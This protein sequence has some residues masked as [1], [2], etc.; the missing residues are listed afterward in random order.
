M[1]RTHSV[2]KQPQIYLVKAHSTNSSG[3]RQNVFH[4]IVGSLSISVTRSVSKWLC[5]RMHLWRR[6]LGGRLPPHRP[7][8]HLGKQRGFKL[9]LETTRMRTHGACLQESIFHCVVNLSAG[10]PRAQHVD[11]VGGPHSAAAATAGCPAAGSAA[12]ALDLVERALGRLQP[13]LPAPTEIPARFR[14]RWCERQWQRGAGASYAYVKP[15]AVAS[16]ASGQCTYLAKSRSNFTIAQM[17]R[18]S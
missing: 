3:F 14:M 10:Q 15:A 16:A 2:L 13:L 12:G 5:A 1:H 4:C 17:C 7:P 9:C 6:F 18:P 11:E 8:R